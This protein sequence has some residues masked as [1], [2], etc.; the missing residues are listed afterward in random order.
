MTYADLAK[1]EDAAA[2]LGQPIRPDVTLTPVRGW[3]VLGQ[4][5]SRP[6]A[7]DLV[8]GAHR[9]PSD[10]GAPRHAVRQGPAR[11]R[12]RRDARVGR[13]LGGEGHEGRRRGPRGGLRRLRRAVLVPRDPGAGRGRPDGLVEDHARSP[14]RA[15]TCSSTCARRREEGEARTDEKGSVE[16]A[17]GQASRVL[18]ES[19]H[20]AYIQHAPMEP[21]AAVAEWNG[22]R[23]TV[24]AGCDGPFR[25]QQIL[26]DGARHPAGARPRDRARHGRRVRRQAHRRGGRSRRRASPGPPGSPSRCAGPARRS[27][28]GRTSA[29]RR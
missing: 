1:V 6:N 23:V 12:L 29:R 5:V 7:R 20:V 14:S 8:T 28:P 10:V 13:P 9:F 25:A 4:S 15:R 21:R 16:T 18:A 19:Y 2:I 24:W 3:K 27:S 11:P 26:A 17:L 22:D